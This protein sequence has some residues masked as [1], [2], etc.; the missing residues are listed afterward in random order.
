MH[1]QG[2]QL[3]AVVSLLSNGQACSDVAPFLCGAHLVAV[4]KPKG[5][6]R[7]I[8]IGELLRRLT[9]KCLM[10]QVQAAGREHFFPAQV[11]VAVPAGAEAVVHCA[12][13][14]FERH[15]GSA[16]KALVKLDF[17]NA[18]NT[19]SRNE[20]LKAVQSH[21][22]SLSRWVSWCY[23][24][25]SNL[26]FGNTT[27]QWLLECNK[28]TLSAPYCLPLLCSRWQRSSEQGP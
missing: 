17:E 11:G 23:G 5:G 10:A 21:F 18:F 12:R 13:A 2:H 16:K 1:W 3:A 14:W 4:P 20:V 19:V 25:A 26:Q 9:G 27:L 8:A 22:P 24:K 28:E 15:S 7:P 6:V